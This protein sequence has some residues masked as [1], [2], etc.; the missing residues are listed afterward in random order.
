M[1]QK[2]AKE[3]LDTFCRALDRKKIDYITHE[4]GLSVRFPAEGEHYAGELEFLVD[5]RREQVVLYAPF[6]FTVRAVRRLDMAVAVCALSYGFLTGT[7]DYDLRKGQIRY[8]ATAYYT[9]SRMD[10]GFFMEMIDYA[11]HFSDGC[12]QKLKALNDGTVTVEQ[13]LKGE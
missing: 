6:P 4:A 7:L 11:I 10:V 8:R 2:K 13:I 5:S 1:K 9:D 12:I 3:M